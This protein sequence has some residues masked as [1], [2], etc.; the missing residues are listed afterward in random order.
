LIFNALLLTLCDV[1][2]ILNATSSSF[3]AKMA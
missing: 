3:I 1:N 2:V